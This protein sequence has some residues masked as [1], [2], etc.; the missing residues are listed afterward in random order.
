MVAA[1]AAAAAAAADAKPLTLEEVR[2][3]VEAVS[4]SVRLEFEGSCP[5][6]GGSGG[7]GA[8]SGDSV[9]S[10][11]R[12]PKGRYLTARKSI[13]AGEI[14]LSEIPLFQGTTEGLQS[15]KAYVESFVALADQE[16][17]ELDPEDDCMHPCSALIDCV[18]GI[19]LNKRESS[20]A[21]EKS[22]R[23]RATLR[24][25]Q[26]AAL[27]QSATAETVPSYCA[28]EI[29]DVLRPELQELTSE[30][31]IQGFLRTLSS[32]RFGANCQLDL[33]F[34]ASMFEHSCMPNVFAGSWHRKVGEQARTYRA[35]R[36]IEEGEALSI[37]YLSMPDT[38]LSVS[39]RAERLSGWDFV[40]RC[41][42]CASQPDLTRSFVC[43]ACSAPELCPQP[44][45]PDARFVCLA[46]RKEPE[47]EYVAR[48]LSREEELRKDEEAELPLEGDGVLSRFHHLVFELAWMHMDAGP[49][50]MEDGATT[51]RAA[52]KVL[53]GCTSRLYGDP[54]HPHL[55]DL[56]HSMAMLE[57]RDVQMQLKYLN[58]ERNCLSMCYSVEQDH[59]DEE[60]M[61]MVQG[62]GG[63][64]S[65][66]AGMD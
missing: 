10:C 9:S 27:C 58:L 62:R 17:E 24:L 25:R 65:M 49:L 14:A 51:F 28:K 36:D 66:L 61:A 18:A 22:H 41:T 60:I 50:V 15:R 7:G 35:L 55:I 34:A 26:F 45:G 19:I 11:S 30:E 48:C 4:P 42:R 23:A 37:D 52:V 56:Y 32:N 57:Q 53:I 46:C 12:S 59:L 40:C 43:P 39:G 47:A 13:K 3:L 2:K 54:T 63:P 21:Q 64:E 33:M 6:A 16:D 31:E 1:A 20:C 44:G 38:Y 29:F 8:G 5:D